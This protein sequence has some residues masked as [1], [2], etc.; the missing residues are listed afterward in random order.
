MTLHH[1]R[2]ILC[3]RTTISLDDHLGM[4][5]KE[6]AAAAGL[7]VSAFLSRALREILT[8]PAQSAEAPPFHLVTVGH[9]DPLPSADLDRTSALLCA[10][11]EALYRPEPE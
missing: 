11:D 1:H 3:M 10:E 8:R 9:G 2:M 7:S 5:L 4:L 6:R